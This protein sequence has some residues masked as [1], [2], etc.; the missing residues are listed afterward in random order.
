[1]NKRGGGAHLFSAKQKERVEGD[2]KDRFGGSRNG[3]SDAM[4][5]ASGASWAQTAPV[6]TLAAK[7]NPGS[8]GTVRSELGMRI[9]QT[10]TNTMSGKRTSVQAPVGATAGAVMQIVSVDPLWGNPIND[11][12]ASAAIPTYEEY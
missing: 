1:V 3:L 12:L 6:G 10:F 5:L 7:C 11:I 2:A 4:L 8:G 9:A